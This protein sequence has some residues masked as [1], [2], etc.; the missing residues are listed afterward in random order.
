[1]NLFRIW[2]CICAGIYLLR[3]LMFNNCCYI[4]SSTFILFILFNK[5]QRALIITFADERHFSII[6]NRKLVVRKYCWLLLNIIVIWC[7]LGLIIKLDL[8]LVI[9]LKWIWTWLLITL[10][11]FFQLIR[12]SIDIKTIWIITKR[13]SQSR[14]IFQFII[15]VM[16]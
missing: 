5:Y 6:K 10:L 2:L 1:M 12:L 3:V 15:K 11:F 8:I 7:V 13:I 14:Y 4:S 16:A 9:F